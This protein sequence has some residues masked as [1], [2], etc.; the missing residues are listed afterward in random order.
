MVIVQACQN[1]FQFQV[2]PMVWG[3][4]GQILP[5]GLCF[6]YLGIFEDECCFASWEIQE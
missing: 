2:L 4:F 5:L 6:G 3:I 1:P